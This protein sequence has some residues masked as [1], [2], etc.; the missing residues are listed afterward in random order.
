VRGGGWGTAKMAGRTMR[1]SLLA[2]DGQQLRC[3]LWRSGAERRGSG[4]KSGTESGME[5]GME[6]LRKEGNGGRRGDKDGG[7]EGC[8]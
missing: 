1:S 4:E 7:E 2:A 6:S 5:S 3:A 8:A